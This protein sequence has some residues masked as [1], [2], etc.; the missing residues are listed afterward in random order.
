[1][2]CSFEGC[3]NEAKRGGLCWAHLKQRSRD[4]GRLQEVRR[5]P[6]SRIERLTEAALA[7]A[8]AETEEE[9]RRARDNL[10]KS[11]LAAGPELIGELTRE[12]LARLRAR[13]VRL[14]RPPKVDPVV[15]A[16]VLG[17]AG[18][19]AEA[20]ARLGVHPRTLRRAVER[21]KRAGCG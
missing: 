13:G 2:L 14:G 21:A 1:M 15:A 4:D 6:E 3:P 17:E 20:A 12:A 9:F 10:R 8:A 7:Y 16:R 11:A 5:R 18:G 19:L